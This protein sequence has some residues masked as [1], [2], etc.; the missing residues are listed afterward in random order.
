MEV[1]MMPG[2]GW[3]GYGMM[4]GYGSLGLV[5]WIINLVLTV[6]ILIGLIVL[7]IWAVRRITK[8]QGGSLFS[9][10]QGGGLTTAREILQTRYARGEITREEYKEILEDIQ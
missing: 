4:S 2:F 5:G 9:S 1:K 3:D 7:V 6:G 10:G 8:S